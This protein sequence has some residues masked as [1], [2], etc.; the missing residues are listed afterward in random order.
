[1]AGT[2][3]LTWP[4][5]GTMPGTVIEGV[6]GFATWDAIGQGIEHDTK[7]VIGFDAENFSVKINVIR[8][9]KR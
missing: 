7:Y 3:G 6:S 5:V 2:G 9:I 8:E 1:M 4:G